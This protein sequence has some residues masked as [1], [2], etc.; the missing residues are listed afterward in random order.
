MTRLEYLSKFHE[1]S[2]TL[3]GIISLC[4]T[5]EDVKK[6]ISIYNPKL[7][8]IYIER[9]RSLGEESGWSKEK[10]TNVLEII[11]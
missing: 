8:D 6:Y 11:K 10:L 2:G 5:L 7:N 9:I 1:I 4:D 3:I